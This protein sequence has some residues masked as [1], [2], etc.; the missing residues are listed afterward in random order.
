[1]ALRLRKDV[2]KASYYV[3]FLGAQEAKGLRGSRVLLPVIPRLIEKSKEHEPLK[4][5]LQISH[6]GLKIIQGSAKHFIPHGAITCSVQTEDIVACILLL[7]NPATKCPLHVHAYRCDSETTAQALNDQLQILI[8]RPDNQK[9]FAELETRLG[10]PAQLTASVVTA[11][12]ERKQQMPRRFASP[13]RFDSSHGSDTG[14]ST[15]ESECSEEQQHS[16]TSPISPISSQSKL[17]DSLAAELREKLSGGVPLLLPAKD[18]DKTT[19]N[20]SR[21]CRNPCIVGSN[22]SVG[23]KHGVSSRGSSGIGSDLAPSPERQDA[24]S[25][26]DEEWV[27]EPE[28]SFA[29]TSHQRLPNNRAK[30]RYPEESMPHP[31]KYREPPTSY[32]YPNVRQD[33]HARF[34]RSSSREEDNSLR[35]SVNSREE[36]VKPIIT[37]PT[38]LQTRFREAFNNDQFAVDDRKK[39]IT[40]DDKRYEQEDIRRK[41]THTDRYLENDRGENFQ[42]KKS[43][44]NGKYYDGYE[45]ERVHYRE[46]LTDRQKYREIISESSKYRDELVKNMSYRDEYTEYSPDRINSRT[47]YP[48]S[49]D[50]H[51]DFKIEREFREHPRSSSNREHLYVHDGSPEEQFQGGFND[52]RLY[53]DSE[54]DAFKDPIEKVGKVPLTRF[55]SS[56]DSKR[57][58]ERYDDRWERQ[59]MYPEDNGS[60]EQ[61]REV[62]S[63]YR[64]DSRN[65]TSVKHVDVRTK[66][67]DVKTSSPESTIRKVSP[68]DRFQNAKEKFQQMERE[69]HEQERIERER[70]EREQMIHAKRTAEAPR[71]SSLEAVV[72][73]SRDSNDWSSDEEDNPPRVP[74]RSSN[75]IGYREV[76]TTNRYPGLDREPM[77]ARV[78]PAKSLGNLVKGY[79]HS[80]AEARPPP[81]SRSSGRVGLAAVN[82]Y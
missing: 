46:N 52:R 36:D 82:P 2:Q 17:Y 66:T 3:W 73:S 80:Y 77:P 16:P 29:S 18:C 23:N 47:K 43:P 55:K 1:M 51:R 44:G 11:A 38:P 68:K 57:N 76:E 56:D 19:V 53:R 72:V 67:V 81:V 21:R 37:K 79:R 71:R 20:D 31:N 12:P 64:D 39:K 48:P 32:L 33:H 59:P 58:R 9:R 50:D 65:S 70:Q 78:M 25:S 7:Y 54:L 61:F 6:K 75:S 40:I 26:S 69:R 74:I 60:E 4:I 34:H 13:R 49:Y 42:F 15:R 45:K 30:E 22:T 27:N 8:N 35:G 24:H 63:R 41:S 28:V 14:T 10:L 5:T 62:S